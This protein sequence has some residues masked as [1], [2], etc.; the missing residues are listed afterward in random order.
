MK[1]YLITSDCDDG[2]VCI[3]AVETDYERAKRLHEIFHEDNSD[4]YI[5]EWDTRAYADLIAGKIPYCVGFRTG[6]APRVELAH[7]QLGEIPAVVEKR[8]YIDVYVYAAS[9]DE[10][11]QKAVEIHRDYVTEKYFK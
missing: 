9:K 11:Y 6:H 2:G 10:A 5:E 3:H 4:V 1:V 8:T 7:W